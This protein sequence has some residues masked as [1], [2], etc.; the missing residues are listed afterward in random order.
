MIY[1]YILYIYNACI[2]VFLV[3]QFANETVRNKLI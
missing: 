2:L 3:L 1:I